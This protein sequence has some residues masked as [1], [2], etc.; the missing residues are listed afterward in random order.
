MKKRIK[1]LFT[2]QCAVSLQQVKRKGLG[3]QS[4]KKRLICQPKIIL[5]LQF[6]G[7]IVGKTTKRGE[8][9]YL[10]RIEVN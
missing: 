10:S 8:S 1:S 5:G 6:K 3:K 2:S 7:F 4:Q 9:I